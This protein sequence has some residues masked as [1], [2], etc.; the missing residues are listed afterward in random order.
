[1]KATLPAVFFVL[2]LMVSALVGGVDVMVC[3]LLV[4]VASTLVTGSRVEGSSS[5]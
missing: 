3:N 2:L 5:L 1:M 4:N